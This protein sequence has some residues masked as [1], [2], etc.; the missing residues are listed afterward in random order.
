MSVFDVE[1]DPKAIEAAAKDEPPE[2]IPT[3]DASATKETAATD[4]TDNLAVPD[5]TTATVITAEAVATAAAIAATTN[6]A[7]TDTAATVATS[8]FDKWKTVVPLRDEEEE[9]IHYPEPSM[10]D[11]FHEEDN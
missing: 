10:D 2:Y 6:N 1:V 5:E 7:T 11:F 4:A 8:N 3:D 9:D